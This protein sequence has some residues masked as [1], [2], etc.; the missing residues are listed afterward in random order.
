MTQSPTA[1]GRI[2]RRLHRFAQLGLIDGFETHHGADD[3]APPYA[4]TIQTVGGDIVR[5]SRIEVPQYLD[6]LAHG[7]HA[8]QVLHGRAR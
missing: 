4:Y 3:T 5:L 7:A 1:P 8:Q 6:G 2:R